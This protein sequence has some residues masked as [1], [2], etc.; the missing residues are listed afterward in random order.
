MFNNHKNTVIL[1]GDFN[2]DTLK[3]NKLSIEFESFLLS[4][5]LKLEIMQPTRLGSKTCL[6][7]FA[8]NIRPKCEYKIIELALSDHTAQILINLKT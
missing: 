3:R 1:C 8:H 7:N 6:D 5:N 4:Y 2:I